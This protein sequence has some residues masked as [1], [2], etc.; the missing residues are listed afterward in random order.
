MATS[1]WPT[2]LYGLLLGLVTCTIVGHIFRAER[3]DRSLIASAITVY[4]LLGA[5]WGALYLI[6]YRTNPG[7]FNAPNVEPI[8]ASVHFVYYSYVTLTTLGYGDITPVSPFARILSA[9]EAVTG[10]L[11][12]GILIARLIS[13][14]GQDLRRS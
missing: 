12:T 10:V 2:V 6:I 14:F 8:Y 11:Y 3:I 13:L 4:L 7:A 1:A 5:I 9:L